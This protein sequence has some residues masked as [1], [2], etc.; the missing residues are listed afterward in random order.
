MLL[1]SMLIRTTKNSVN[2]KPILKF[3]PN[4]IAMT[5][6]TNTYAAIICKHNQ[7]LSSVTMI[8]VVSFMEE[9]LVLQIDVFDPTTKMKK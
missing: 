2:N 7:Y 6:G 3:I 5:I 8:P 4:G 9:T 1:Y